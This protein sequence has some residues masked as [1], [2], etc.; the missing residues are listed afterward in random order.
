[1]RVST[2]DYLDRDGSTPGRLFDR[3]WW[4]RDVPRP[5]PVCR[6][7]GH[8]PVVDGTGTPGEHSGHVA[9]WVACDRCGVRP[10]PQGV[11]DPEQWDI[12]QPYTG[13]FVTPP[14]AGLEGVARTEAMKRTKGWRHP[15]PWPRRPT[16][17]IGGQLVIGRSIPGAGLGVKV[18]NAASEHVLEATAHVGPLGFIGVHTEHLGQ[19]VQ[20]RLNPKGYE[21]RVVEASIHGGRLHWKLW[22]KR[23]SWTRGTPRWRDGSVRIDLRDILLGEARYTY[24]LREGPVDAVVRMP[25]GDDHDVKLTLTLCR[26]G[27]PRGRRS[28]GSWEVEWTSV[29]GIPFRR[30]SWKGNNVHGSAVSVSAAAVRQGRWVQEAS[31]AIAAQISADRSR[32]GW[33]PDTEAEAS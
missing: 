15:G 18:G 1:M 14:W 11:L 33:R 30:D 27:R 10:D 24:E 28:I 12:G 31:A 19:G 6:L 22:A 21:S 7:L 17:V 29:P 13:P 9:R 32:Y 5:M 3:G 4:L 20:R 8:R 16:G 2:V 25:E 26:L 23:D